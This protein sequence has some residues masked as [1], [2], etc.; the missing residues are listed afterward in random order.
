M[1]RSALPRAFIR[2]MDA[3]PHDDCAGDQFQKFM[4]VMNRDE[5]GMLFEVYDDEMVDDFMRG[6]RKRALI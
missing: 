6:C 1:S 2:I 3:D 5:G 4:K